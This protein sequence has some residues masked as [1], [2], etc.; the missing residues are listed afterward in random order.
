MRWAS[1][2]FGPWL[3]CGACLAAPAVARAADPPGALGTL[4]VPGGADALAAAAGLT[5][6][7]SR[8]TLLL[9][10]IRRLHA[11]ADGDR[12]AAGP[13]RVAVAAALGGAPTEDLVPLPFTESTWIRVVFR[14]RVAPASLARAIVETPDA[15]WLY[16]GGVGLDDATRAW[17]A[18][19]PHRLLRLRAQAGAF[20]A[21]GPSLRIEGERVAVPGGPPADAAWA[22][23]IGE[24][25]ADAERFVDRLFEKSDGRAAWLYDVVS[26]LDPGQQRHLLDGAGASD[27]LRRLADVF[28]RVSPEWRIAERPY[29]RP[30]VDPAALV[31]E[32]P[33]ADDG[34]LAIGEDPAAWTGTFGRPTAVDLAWLAE[35]VFGG[36]LAGV[37]DRFELVAFAG[38][39]ARAG[40]PPSAPVLDLFQAAPVLALTL[41]RIGVRDGALAAR[42]L[43][44]VQQDGAREHG[45]GMTLLQASFALIERFALAGSLD[46]AAAQRQ[47]AAL[48]DRIAADGIAAGVADWIAGSVVPACS[49]LAPGA[50]VDAQLS[51]C[52]AGPTPAS[53]PRLEWEGQRYTVDPAGAVRDRL[54]RVQDVFG[55]PAVD[56]ALAA[57]RGNAPGSL[58][59]ALVALVYAAVL[60][61]TDPELLASRVDR[62]HVFGSGRHGSHRAWRLAEPVSAAGVP[63]HLEGSLLA[64][65]VAMAVQSLRRV[66]EDPPSP[67]LPGADRVAFARTVALLSPSRM[68]DA[69]R[70]TVVRLLARG[71]AR[72]RAI[73]DAASA[74]SAARAA[75]ISAWRREGLAWSVAHDPASIGRTL[76]LTETL[77]LGEPRPEE[78]VALDA[79]GTS[80][81]AATGELAS[82]LPPPGPWEE[83]IS[84]DARAGLAASVADLNL[85]VAQ[86]LASRTLPA[87]IARDVLS[88]ATQ[89]LV[90][91]V[92]APRADDVR[93]VVAAI[94]RI[95]DTRLEDYVAAITGDGAMRPVREPET[96]Q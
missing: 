64:L 27:R 86:F 74:R 65:D 12:A 73:G 89:E 32:V 70:D 55:P 56:A 37:R 53:A 87:A 69:S 39:W 11:P 90:D 96:G 62:R 38:R 13:R 3:A 19:R 78:R 82:R 15:A 42:L 16:S 49:P 35:R 57:A 50:P 44:L 80:R 67:T 48:A 24:S 26:R 84:H 1:L 5:A 28:A 43:S 91:R 63:W 93:A 45:P 40:T 10:V 22:A 20:A 77:W 94:G 83:A 4:A 33:A 59:E 8:G 81:L 6:P 21:F 54:A 66:S 17:F 61:T 85:R 51:A 7:A 18:S 23:L 95:D 79:W 9:D 76:S 58:A 71:D 31:R 14:G 68:T 2:V 75:G 72:L 52:L 41:E 88:A 46:P 47:L 34:R 36:E 30:L 29:W 92:E 60:P 25:P